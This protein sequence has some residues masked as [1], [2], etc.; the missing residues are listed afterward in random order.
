VQGKFNDLTGKRFGRLVVIERV[1]N[2]KVGSAQWL[3]KCDCGN[4]TIVKTASI[5]SGGTLSCGCVKSERMK[6]LGY[7]R[8]K[9]DSNSRL[10]HIWS[11]IKQRCFNSNQARYKDYGGRGI[12]MCDEWKNDFQAFYD[13]AM[14]NGYKDDL[15]IDRI[16]VNG[17]YCPENCRW[18]TMKEQRS[19]RRDSKN[20]NANE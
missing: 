9:Y 14:A 10:Y 15:T 11:G 17:S 16:D 8:R 3:C 13:W 7:G 1:A 6:L 20:C 2:N 18:A 12:T 19:N 4:Q 5:N